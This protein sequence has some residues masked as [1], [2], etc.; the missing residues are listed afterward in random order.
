RVQEAR[1][2][3]GTRNARQASRARRPSALPSPCAVQL[4]Y[5]SAAI[6]RPARA[7]KVIHV[8]GFTS[9]A[10]APATAAASAGGHVPTRSART[11]QYRYAAARKS[12]VDSIMKQRDQKTYS[13]L[14]TR[15]VMNTSRWERTTP[16]SPSSSQR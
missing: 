2:V 9:A 16:S 7:A 10:S 8:V 13:G 5:A 11:T 1:A 6:A 12:A 3:I 15:R 4:R 14:V